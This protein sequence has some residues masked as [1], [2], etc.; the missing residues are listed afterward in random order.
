[1][2]PSNNTTDARCQGMCGPSS[3]RA[4]DA[5]PMAAFS[6][7]PL[8]ASFVREASW[9]GSGIMAMFRSGR[10]TFWRRSR[11]ENIVPEATTSPGTSTPPRPAAAM[12]TGYSMR[13]APTPK[14]PTR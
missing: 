14:R 8:T 11:S 12:I 4:I 6:T 1:M 5:M 3:N 10:C 13:L 7:T 2:P 9:G